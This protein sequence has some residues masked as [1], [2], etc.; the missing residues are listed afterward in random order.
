MKKILDIAGQVAFI[1]L[2]VFVLFFPY[3]AG[4]IAAHIATQLWAGFLSEV[5]MDIINQLE[6]E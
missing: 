4:E 2:L 5:D 3:Q 6:T 1:A